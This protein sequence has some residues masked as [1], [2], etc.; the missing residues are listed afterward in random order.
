MKKRKVPVRMCVSC[1]QG[2]PKKEM[3]RIVKTAEGLK[4]DLTGKADGRGAYICADINCFEK[5]SKSKAVDRAL[6][7]KMSE[8]LYA[9]VKRAILRRGMNLDV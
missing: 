3:F 5:L 6:E 1:R 2:K 9:E 4:L 8:E 7:D